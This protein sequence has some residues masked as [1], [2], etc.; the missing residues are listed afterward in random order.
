[1]KRFTFLSLALALGI[2]SPT[3][4]DTELG[5][6]RTAVSIVMEDRGDSR[7]FRPLKESEQNTVIDRVLYSYGHAHAVKG[8]KYSIYIKNKTD[9]R[10]LACVAVDGRSVMNGDQIGSSLHLN[11]TW[12]D[13]CYIVSANSH[14]PIDGWRDSSATIRRFYFT[15][16]AASLAS[17]K[18]G[19]RSAV[20]TIAVAIFPEVS[21]VIAMGRSRSQ[22]QT[23][24]AEGLGT[25]AGN[26]EESR[27]TEVAFKAETLAS[28]V[29]VLHYA[30]E[31][32]LRE[33]GLWQDDTDSSFGR[34][35]KPNKFI[36]FN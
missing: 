23:R 24:G 9:R 2:A 3:L 27:V 19:D 31:S 5:S 7:I 36:D 15:S 18:W 32:A 29:L 21:K 11:D 14:L 13:N 16:A 26:R 33:A 22:P 20:S 1:M 35:K 25:G 30:T 17:W 6:S 8:Q 10:V 4:A 34:Y 28:D 12:G